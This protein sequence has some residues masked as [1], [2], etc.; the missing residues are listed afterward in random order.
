MKNNFFPVA[1]EGWIYIIYSLLAASIFYALD[2]MLLS[3]LSSFLLVNYLFIFR[4][5]ER[6]LPTFQDG[7]VVSPCDGIVQAITEVDDT[8][9]LYRVDIDS[10]YLDV[11]VLRVPMNAALDSII[12]KNGSRSSQK[13]KL[14]TDLNENTQ[15]IFSDKVGN[16]LKIVH[17]LKQSLVPLFTDIK[18]SQ[19]LNQTQRYG[20]MNNG[21]TTVYF[22]SNFR[23]D[24]HVGDELR[25]SNSLVGYFS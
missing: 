19:Q 12:S 22:P 18:K 4:N 1:K 8:E 25:A 21:V 14:F 13:S 9:F 15:L 2:L 23:L 3:L 11:S 7:C 16:K 17:T 20:I 6:N 5:P 24:I 10:S